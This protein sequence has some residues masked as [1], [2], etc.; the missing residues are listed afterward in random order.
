[1]A[2]DPVLIIGAGP[3]GLVLALTLGKN[4][5]PVRIME[6]EPSPRRAERG[7]GLQPRS[8]ELHKILGTLPDI[9][10]AGTD[11]PMMT[12]YDPADGTKVIKTTILVP[13][14]EATPQLPL[15]NPVMLGQHY[16]ER[17]LRDH[18]AKIGVT[19]EFGSELRT[20]TQTEDHVLAQI[21]RVVDG[22]DVI[23]EVK[24]VWMVGTDG[25]HSVV[26]K[27]LGLEFLGE[28]RYSEEIIVGDLKVKG[29]IRETWDNWGSPASR[30]ATLRPSG[31]KD[32]VAQFIIAGRDVDCSKVMASSENLFE[33]FYTIT[34]RRDIEFQELISVAKY[35]PN[36]RMAKQLRS[37][38]VFIGGDAAHCHS[39]AGGQFNLGWKLALVYKGYAPASLLD[40]YEEERIPIIAEMLGKTTELHN[41]TISRGHG[42]SD[43]PRDSLLKQLGVNYRGSSIV[44]ED[45]VEI[46]TAKTTGYSA[47]SE[48]AARPGD[49]APGAP[50]LV[51]TA[52]NIQTY[53]IYDLF[54][55]SR[56]TILIFSDPSF[57]YLS[58]SKT[59]QK[60]RN[61]TVLGVLILSK[62]TSLSDTDTTALFDKTVADRDGFAFSGYH[63]EGPTVVIV[64]PDGVIG[65][66]VRGVSGIE[67]YFKGIFA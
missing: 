5:I 17:I 41:H 67:R 19:V 27:T 59:I 29:A 1:M 16:Q 43:M 7:P 66:R 25:A 46:P 24:A 47:E 34:G 22:K 37:H 39:P 6:K 63:I 54:A 28:T 57:D 65:A 2:S 30:M 42:I 53:E 56:H 3:S 50:G 61:G 13:Q 33:E 38:R 55:V 9:L 51:D 58:L 10:N 52:G 62:G 23:E 49:R 48:T 26:R 60:F 14:T 40:T 18:L 15:I 8:L 20:F 31:Q 12:V 21:V 32:N 44:Y 11:L 4:G 45:D 35:R 64:R 36:I